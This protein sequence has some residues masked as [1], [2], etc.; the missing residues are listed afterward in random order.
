MEKELAAARG[1]GWEEAIAQEFGVDMY[2]LLYLKLITNEDILCSTG[3]SAQS[4]VAAWVGE[5][6]GGNG[7]TYM[8]GLG[9]PPWLSSEESTCNAGDAG[10]TGSIPGLGRSSGGGNSNP[11]QYSCWEKSHGERSLEGSNSRTQ[12]SDWPCT[13]VRLSPSA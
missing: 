2:T 3:N 9:L 13:H 12:L 8:Y 11:L 7:Y 4:N 10:N 1:Q 6:F 5:E